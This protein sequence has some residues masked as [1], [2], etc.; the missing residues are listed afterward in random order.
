[1]PSDPE[2]LITTGN[3]V[4]MAV[5]LLSVVV[6]FWRIAVR[7]AKLEMKLNMIWNW[8]KHQ[9]KIKEDHEDTE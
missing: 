5:S 6:A 7:L 9:H 4:N 2:I 3:I 1:M 8:Y